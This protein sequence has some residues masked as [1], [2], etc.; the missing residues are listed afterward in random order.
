MV[1]IFPILTLLMYSV[2]FSFLLFDYDNYNQDLWTS[3]NNYVACTFLGYYLG[4]FLADKSKIDSVCISIWLTIFLLAVLDGI[5]YLTDLK[6]LE[7]YPLY[8][9]IYITILLL[10]FVFNEIFKKNENRI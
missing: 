9:S 1:R 5:R 10:T 6:M 4:M 2:Q 8:K 3:I 7:Y